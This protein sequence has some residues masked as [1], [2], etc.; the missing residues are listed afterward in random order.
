MSKFYVSGNKRLTASTILLTL[1]KDKS[2][3]P[4]IFQPGQYASL[5]FNKNGRST[6]TRCFSI[7]NSP[8]D[9]NLIQCSIRTKGKF[10]N[11]IANITEGEEVNVRGS[12]GGFTF[13]EERDKDTVMLA[14][15]IGVAPF[16]SMIQY[17]TAR[18]LPNKMTLIYCCNNQ[19]DIP[20]LSQLIDLEKQNHNFKIVF[21]ISN[22][23][24]DKLKGQSVNNG[25]I[26]SEVIDKI[27]KGLYAK[28]TFFICGPAPFMNAMTSILLEQGVDNSRIMTEAFSQGSNRQT[29]KIR[30]WPIN[31][32][33]LGVIGLVLGSASIMLNDLLSFLPS[34][35]TTPNTTSCTSTPSATTNTRQGE[36]DEIDEDSPNTT[37]ST[38]TSCTPSTT[39]PTPTPV[40]AP[41]CTTTQSGKCI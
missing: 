11:A 8:T 21:V 32:Y 31:I 41:A 4:F 28:R 6:P 26:T 27:V 39:N 25:R 17:A 35:P 16:M 38:N 10:T 29:G 14:G 40:P 36:L 30:S 22:G 5:S 3:K 13:D 20:F 37:T 23:S 15:G 33:A 9:Q 18:K 2:T 24:T 1:R 34:T 12:F 7:V 19:D